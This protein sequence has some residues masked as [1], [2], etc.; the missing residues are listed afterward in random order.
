MLKKQKVKN[1]SYLVEL[2]EASIYGANQF[3]L[4]KAKYLCIHIYNCS[5]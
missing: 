3:P 1:E 5:R 4:Q 2:K